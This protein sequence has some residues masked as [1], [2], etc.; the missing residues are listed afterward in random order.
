MSPSQN[1]YEK[2]TIFMILNYMHTFEDYVRV[3]YAECTF[4]IVFPK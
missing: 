1:I 4:I 2:C 3:K